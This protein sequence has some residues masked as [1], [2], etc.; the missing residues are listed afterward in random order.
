VNPREGEKTPL[1][2]KRSIC[3]QDA[4]YKMRFSR[5]LNASSNPLRNHHGLVKWAVWHEQSKLIP[6]NAR[7]N[8]AINYFFKEDSRHGPQSVVTDV[9]PVLVVNILYP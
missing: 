4:V 1:Q 2:L 6:S 5:K 8:R 3:N 9:V 7:S